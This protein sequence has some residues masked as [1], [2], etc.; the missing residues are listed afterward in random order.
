MAK[1]LA[2]L[3]VTLDEIKR[4]LPITYVLYLK[5]CHPEGKSGGRFHYINPFRE[6]RNPSLDV[7][8]SEDQIQRWGDFAE[9]T[10]GSVIDLVQRFE[11]D[12]SLREVMPVVRRMYASYLEEDDWDEDLEP[13]ERLAEIEPSVLEFETALPVVTSTNRVLGSLYAGRPGVTLKSLQD[14]EVR[15]GGSYLAAIYP[16]GKAIRIRD[17]RDKWFRAGSKTSLYHAP[18]KGPDD[19]PSR[20]ILLVEGE[21][22]AW[23]AYGAFGRKMVVAALPGTGHTKERFISSLMG[24]KVVLGFDGDTAGRKFSRF[25]AA[26]LKDAGCSVSV[27]P[28]PEGRDLASFPLESLSDLMNRRRQAT[29]NVTNLRAAAGGYETVNADGTQ[30]TLLSNWWLEVIEI[31]FSETDHSYVVRAHSSEGPF[32]GEFVLTT[33]DLLSS[34]AMM[35]WCRKFHGSWWGSTTDAQKLVAELEE[36]S[37]YVP[38]TRTV[39]RPS[40]VKPGGFSLPGLSVGTD[41]KLVDDSRLATDMEWPVRGDA[42]AKTLL[43][44]LGMHTPEVMSP[45][46]AWLAMAPLRSLYLQFPQLFV[47]GAAGSGKTTIVERSLRDLSNVTTSSA[48]TSATPYAV[49][50]RMGGGNCLPVWFDEYRPGGRRASIETLDQMM[51]DAY[52]ST[53]SFRGGMTEDKSQVTALDTDAPLIVSG[54]DMADEQSHRDRLVRVVIPLKG[55]GVLPRRYKA[56]RLLAQEYLQ[57]LVSRGQD[58]SPS[59]VMKPPVIDDS[60]Y[61]ELGLNERQA[62]NLGVL[63]AGWALLSEFVLFLSQG[64][65]EWP[66]PDWSG[67]L[68]MA[69]EDSGDKILEFLQDMRESWGQ[70]NAMWYHE[71]K[72][73]SYISPVLVMKKAREERQ[74]LLPFRNSRVLMSHLELNHEGVRINPRSGLVG[75]GKIRYLRFDGDFWKD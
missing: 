61:L 7:F 21:S 8:Y 29:V 64:D 69:E 57:W 59:V 72:N 73:R 23:A 3:T 18:G 53:P 27:L 71:A 55:K 5:D 2:S 26:Q 51:R 62:W 54:E 31:L 16:D 9:Q 40:L 49:S 1:S 36:Q 30:T 65:V 46:L 66:D 63:D 41:V 28:L 20:T 14:F 19:Y 70:C 60:P 43:R 12:A 67:L 6:D 22:D 13:T 44:L 24:R 56:D 38:M 58:F 45:I 75:Q 33:K 52:T 48:L 35:V 10:Q 17:E 32:D 50:V 4:N 68:A 39:G 34:Q 37:V 25:W 42:S 15:D 47:T 11:G 74:D